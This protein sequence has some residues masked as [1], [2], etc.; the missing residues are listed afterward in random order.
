MH[1]SLGM[2]GEFSRAELWQRELFASL[3][4]LLC[5]GAESPA[6]GAYLVLGIACL[7]RHLLMWCSQTVQG[8]HRLRR[9]RNIHLQQTRWRAGT[10][11]LSHVGFHRAQSSEVAVLAVPPCR[12]D[13]WQITTLTVVRFCSLQQKAECCLI[14]RW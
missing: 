10:H 8:S 12:C 7:P 6:G 13:L 2:P 9:E 14:M 4:S 5:E 1:E 3:A 11:G